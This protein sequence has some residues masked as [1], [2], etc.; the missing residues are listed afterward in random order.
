MTS[1][2]NQ[3]TSTAADARKAR[4]RGKAVALVSEET[5]GEAGAAPIR[6]EPGLVHLPSGRW[7]V[8]LSAVDP[9]TG[10]RIQRLKTFDRKLDAKKW[11]TETLASI[12]ANAYVAP[13][14]T[15][16]DALADEW[17]AV[18]ASDVR[19][20]THAGYTNALR[21]ARLAFGKVKVQQL[22]QSHVQ[23]L[24]DSMADDGLARGSVRLALY[25]VRSILTSA[26][27]TRL[28]PTNVALAVKVPKRAAPPVAREHLP[29]ADA[30]TI[31]AHVVGHRLEGVWLLTLSGLRRSEVMA[32]TWADL[33]LEAGELTISKGRVELAKAKGGTETNEP[34]ATRSRRTLPLPAPVLAGLRRT[35]AIRAQERL[36]LGLGWDDSALLAVDATQTQIRPQHFSHLWLAMLAELGIP[37]VTLHG[38]RHGSV[39]RMLDSGVPVHVVASWH[40]HDPSM[41]L[42]VYAHSSREGKVAAGEASF[43]F[44]AQA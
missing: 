27:T 18:K 24:V 44:G 36:A 23:A 41:T 33:D 2:T 22:R 39:S 26:V 7:Q 30:A 31:T 37:R 5:P 20:V 12:E 42:S 11:R 25:C 38:A 40:G 35:R 29:A 3:P 43:A 15:T 1:N 19:S 34:K 9:L 10:A 13:T 21:R 16:F 8:K 14:V 6:T 32:V 28:V 4:G 17:L